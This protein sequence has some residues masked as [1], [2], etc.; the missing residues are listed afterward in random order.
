MRVLVVEDDATLRDTLTTCLKGAS[1]SVDCAEDGK[2][3]SVMGRMNHYDAIL[4][5]L[6]LPG[7][8]GENICADVRSI[9]KTAPI[10]V[11]SIA[12]E[13]GRKV[14][15]LNMGADDYL[16]KPFSL[17][18]LLAR[19][20]AVT[21]RP[22]TL[23]EDTVSRGHIKLDR[24]K[25]RVYFR[26]E[27]IY[28]TR[29]EYLLL[30]YLMRHEGIV[31]SRTTLLEQIWGGVLDARTN[32]IETHILSLRKKMRECNIQKCIHTMPGRGYLFEIK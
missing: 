1:Y 31:I 27:E 21:R 28:L 9:G 12:S 25:H 6:G 22:K 5:D 10:I 17:D 32:T 7:R 8:T 2:K 4:L 20:R 3:G 18:E 19:L 11:M 26:N 29:K 13:I 14:D 15:L 24:L 16:V 30:E 23:V